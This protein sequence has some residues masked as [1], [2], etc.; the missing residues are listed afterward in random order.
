MR[1]R[2]INLAWIFY[3]KAALL[4]LSIASFIVYALLLGPELFGLGVLAITL[5][6]AVGVI[7]CSVLEDPMVRRRVRS[8]RLYASV[9]WYGG[10]GALLAAILLPLACLLFDASPLFVALVA[11]SSLKLVMTV[12]S[13]PFVAELRRQR[14]F[15]A[16]ANRTLAGKIVGATAGILAALSGL[17]AWAVV[18]QALLMECCALAMLLYWQRGLITARLK[19]RYFLQLVQSGLP[20]GVKMFSRGMLVRAVTLVLGSVSDATTVGYF[21]FANRLVDLPRLALSDGL[22]SYALPAIAKRAKAGPEVGR[23]ICAISLSTATLMVPMFLGAMMLG[24]DLIHLFFDARWQPASGAFTWLCLLAAFRCLVMYVPATLVAMGKARWG[25]EIDLI[26]L[27]LALALVWLFGSHWGVM[28]AVA[29]VGVQL[30]G[31]LVIKTIQLNK[32][33]RLQWPVLLW[34]Y[35]QIGIACVLMIGAIAWV[36]ADQQTHLA[37]LFVSVVLG[38]TVYLTSLSALKPGWVRGIMNSLRQG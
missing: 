13:R 1:H 33:F 7:F 18:I 23:F 26:L 11:V 22:L 17:G 6:E 20:L 3:E 19:F 15:K 30:S 37:G 12:Q 29:A 8:K 28:A 32:L 34:D 36:Q 9:F 35:A 2:L 4:I 5:I 16:L 21:S 27:L 10:A 31:D 24:G 25:M 38:I 14:N